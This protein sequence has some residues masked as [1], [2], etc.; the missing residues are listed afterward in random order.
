VIDRLVLSS[1]SAA[2]DGGL[3]AIAEVASVLEGAG[4]LEDAIDVITRGLNEAEATQRRTRIRAL[5]AE[6]AGI[7]S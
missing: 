6:V 5:L 3:T 7:A 1:L 4:K 2:M